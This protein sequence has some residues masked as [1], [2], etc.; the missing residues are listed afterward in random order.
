MTSNFLGIYNKHFEPGI[1]E[2]AGCGAP[3]Y[4]SEAKFDSGCGWPA[5]YEAI[6]GQFLCNSQ[7]NLLEDLWNDSLT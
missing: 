4:K 5:F 3:L 7:S 2:C 1:Y 6:P